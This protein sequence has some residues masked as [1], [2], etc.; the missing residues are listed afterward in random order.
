MPSVKR[1]VMNLDTYVAMVAFCIM[2]V[3]VFIQVFTRYVLNLPLSWPEE[4]ARYSL[5][6]LTFLGASAAVRAN[7][8]IRIDVLLMRVSPNVRSLLVVLTNI[9]AAVILIAVT[10]AGFGLVR[11]MIGIPTA[12]LQVSMSWVYL[13]VPLSFSLMIVQLITSSVFGL[14]SLRSNRQGR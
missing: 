2:Q 1:I 7:D 9:C 11:L 12:A 3:C 8:H 4:V 10:P 6:W 5:V 13:P 14:N